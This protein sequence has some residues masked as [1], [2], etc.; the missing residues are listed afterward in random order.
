MTFKDYWTGLSPKE[1]KSLATRAGTQV[2]YLSQIAHGN[3]PGGANLIQKLIE[4]DA[5]IS[6]EM[7]RPT[8]EQAA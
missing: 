5:N 3:R 6:F 4:A 7:I 1:K 2:D 8:K